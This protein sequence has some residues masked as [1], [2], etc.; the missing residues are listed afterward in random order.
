MRTARSHSQSNQPTVVCVS[1]KVPSALFREDYYSALVAFSVGFGSNLRVTGKR[2]V[3]DATLG[4]RHRLKGVFTTARTNSTRHATSKPT[5]HLHTAFPIV[6]DIDYHVGFSTQLAVGDHANQELERLK[7][8]ATSTN[9]QTGV[10]TLNFECHR[11]FVV[12]LTDV[13]FGYDAHRSQEVIEKLGDKLLRL[14]IL[15]SNDRL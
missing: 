10:L 14:F 15:L 8:F 1:E 3:N 7:R 12:I 6:F 5:Q 11:A 9:Q 13:R 4:W 2:H